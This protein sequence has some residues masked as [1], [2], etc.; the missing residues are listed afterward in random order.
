MAQHSGEDVLT[1]ETTGTDP[2]FDKAIEG[3]RATGASVEMVELVQLLA[4]HGTEE[5]RM[6]GTYEAL[7]KST[8]DPAARYLVDL[9]LDDERR[10][11]RML[12]E[13]ANAMAWDSLK[14]APDPAVPRLSMHIDDELIEHTRRLREAE[15]HDRRE[16]AAMRKRLR[17]YADTTMWTLVLD[18][19]LMDTDKHAT[20]LRFL[21][22]HARQG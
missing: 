22:D 2:A 14:K 15:E 19:I 10:H 4:R 7:A 21:E 13:M 6:L 8:D 3:L 1:E 11:H 20:I 18:L 9:I 5:G 16:L 12:A 17:P